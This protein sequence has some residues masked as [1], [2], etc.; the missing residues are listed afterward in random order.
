M[1]QR[2]MLIDERMIFYPIL[3]VDWTYWHL[4]LFV[5]LSFYASVSFRLPT[6]YFT[7]DL[8]AHSHSSDSIDSTNAAEW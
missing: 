5:S 8:L 4:V 2:T 1:L 3:R 7:I 6:N